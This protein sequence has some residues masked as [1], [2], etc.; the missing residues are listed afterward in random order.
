MLKDIITAVQDI[1]TVNFTNQP[2]YVGNVKNLFQR[3]CFLISYKDSRIQSLSR[4]IYREIVTIQIAYFSALDN[5]GCPEAM[6]QFAVYDKLNKIFSEGFIEVKDRKIRLM[7]ISGGTKDDAIDKLNDDGRYNEMF[8]N[9][10]LDITESREEI[11][12]NTATA[13][14]VKINLQ[15][16]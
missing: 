5:N 6:E 8:L 11:L 3:P 12:D 13:S 10:T 4:W 15:E 2:V 9:L 1:V 7:K 16:V 14:S